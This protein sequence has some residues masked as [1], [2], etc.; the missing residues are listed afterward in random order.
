[1]RQIAAARYALD[2]YTLHVAGGI[3]MGEDLETRITDLI[4]DLMHLTSHMGVDWWAVH[5]RALMHFD[6]E[7]EDDS[8]VTEPSDESQRLREEA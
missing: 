4:A 7:R 1:M 2:C 3:G 8:D 6:A 5:D